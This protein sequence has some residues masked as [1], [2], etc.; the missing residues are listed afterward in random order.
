VW[1]RR[2]LASAHR[3]EGRGAIDA[4]SDDWRHRGLELGEAR[5]RPG[6]PPNVK[7][8][9]PDEHTQHTDTRILYVLHSSAIVLP[10][11][12]YALRITESILLRLLT[13]LTCEPQ[14][15]YTARSD[16]PGTT[17]GVAVG[18]TAL[19][20][21][22]QARGGWCTRLHAYT[23]VRTQTTNVGMC[24]CE[25]PG[26]VWS[27]TQTTWFEPRYSNKRSHNAPSQ[28]IPPSPAPITRSASTMRTTSS[29]M[30]GLVS[31]IDI[32]RVPRR[33]LGPHR[34]S[35]FLHVQSADARIQA[36]AR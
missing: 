17:A 27:A 31:I 35:V 6:A 32:D 33:D 29:H 28:G 26:A 11:P 14:Y 8:Q 36:R 5:R 16:G 20:R 21:Y 18:G 7:E 2:R 23:V 22:L 1:R 30:H 19:G 10:N 15:T 34:S 9:R 24:A 4:G 12:G 3:S 25:L 13:K